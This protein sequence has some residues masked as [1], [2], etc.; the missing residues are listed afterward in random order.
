MEYKIMSKKYPRISNQCP[1]CHQGLIEIGK[2]IESAE[3]YVYCTECEMEWSSPLCVLENNGGFY[4][5]YGRVTEPT[6]E[7]IKAKGWDI[8]LID[9]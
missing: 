1:F 9:E 8:Y 3:L 7:E 4:F 6:L 2:D 5:K